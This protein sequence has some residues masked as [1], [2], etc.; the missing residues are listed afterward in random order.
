MQEGVT[1]QQLAE[2]E[3]RFED[4]RA[5]AEP[6]R[7]LLRRQRELA[8][9]TQDA[10]AVLRF[11]ADPMHAPP[12]QHR[13]DVVWPPTRRWRCL[14]DTEPVIRCA[15]SVLA[16]LLLTGAVACASAGGQ[17]DPAGAAA[18]VTATWAKA[19]NIGDVPGPAALYAD[20]ARYV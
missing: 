7:L 6:E 17:L 11:C 20:D 10:T 18:D 19:F 13:P 1:R 4:G 14:M 5:L 3:E 9:D 8:G 16:A 15:R 2:R 12:T